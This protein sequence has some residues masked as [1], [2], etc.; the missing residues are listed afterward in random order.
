MII[1]Y[2]LWILMKYFFIFKFLENYMK[3]LGS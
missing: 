1:I 3:E 2:F